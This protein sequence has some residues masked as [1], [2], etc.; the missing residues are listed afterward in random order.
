[1]KNFEIIHTDFLVIG[2]GI[3]GLSAAYRLSK[4]A[5]VALLSKGPIRESSTA[6]A[7]GGIAVAMQADDTPQFHFED[8]LVAGDGLC[9]EKAV[10]FLVNEGPKSV[11]ELISLGA[12]FDKVGDD[13]DFTREAAHRKRRILHAADATGLEI[14][15]TLG[16]AI[17]KQDAVT[18]FADTSVLRLFREGETCTG[19]LALK[20]NKYLF[21][22]S[23]ATIIATGGAGQVYA[24]NSNP[25]FS[26]GDGIS[27]AF[28]IGCEVQDMEF[29]Q[30][31]PTTLF[32]GDKKPISLFLISEALRGEGGL[33]RNS[34]G[35]AFM[36]RY[37]KDA[38]LA[39]RDVVARAI[40]NEM[41]Q[42]G[43][44]CVYLDVS[45]L[46][47]ILQQRFPNIYKRCLQANINVL[48][49]W[50]PV[51]PAAHYLIG[52]VSVDLNA[53]TNLDNLF[54]C[55]EV[56][57]TGIHGANRLASNS[58]LEG[59]VFGFR[60]AEYC[61]NTTFKN[62]PLPDLSFMSNSSS[63]STKSDLLKIRNQI[64]TCMW[65]HVSIF[66]TQKSLAIAEAI[67][68]KFDAS[69]SK[70]SLDKFSVELNHI[71]RVA[72]LIVQFSQYRLES[73]GTHFRL[74]YP[75]KVDSFNKHFVL[76]K[77]INTPVNK[78]ALSRFGNTHRHQCIFKEVE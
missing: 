47:T 9:D 17:L 33:L 18:F 62:T 63:G 25:V 74:D 15:K 40:V 66:R 69:I 67:L 75:N 8:T 22:K 3:A 28:D 54:A 48:T 51:S 73:R 70:D 2:A 57:A 13:L 5:K 31:H 77:W 26:T 12:N 27:L 68:N 32:E 11:N 56:A 23:K 76:S 42:D 1:M 52:G 49:E 60:A 35:E 24:R 44:A 50:I 16:R 72:K 34:A 21:F 59:L 71:I 4:H 61:L 20:S 55:G 7:Q 64:K 78:E 53:R 6:Y 58:L 10:Q 38:E 14:E 29:V 39:P 36:S 41:K 30:F 46:G 43:N 19:C 45:H 65:E 37:H